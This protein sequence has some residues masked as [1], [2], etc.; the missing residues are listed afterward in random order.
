[1]KKI[2]AG[3]IVDEKTQKQVKEE[4]GQPPYVREGLLANDRNRWFIVALVL[5]VLCL[6]LILN[7]VKAYGRLADNIQVQWVKVYQDGT[8]DVDVEGQD[9]E[10]EYFQ[11]T[12]DYLIRE[13]VQRRYS[14]IRETIRFD[15]GHVQLFMS[16]QLRQAFIDTSG[17]NAAQKA[18][19]VM[20]CAGCDQVEIVVRDIDHYD[21]DDTSFETRLG[22]VQGTLYRSNVFVQEVVRDAT[23]RTKE[24]RNRIVPLQWRLKTRKE[25]EA[26]R[27]IL[28]TNPVGL[29]IRRYDLL[30]QTTS[31]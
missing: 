11:S 9:R 16:P 10:P 3:R 19:D 14:K 12:I 20:D 2:R 7:L 28:K 18:A 24:T 17:F 8:W 15:Y 21:R 22:N 13:W 1:M 27:E 6:V 23:G 26:D 30:D 5:A 25:I 29:E 4:N 31:S